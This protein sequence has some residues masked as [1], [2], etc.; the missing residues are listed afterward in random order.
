LENLIKQFEFN[1]GIKNWKKF[2]NSGGAN[3]FFF[4]LR[5]AYF[6]DYY[7]MIHFFI[8]DFFITLKR[9]RKKNLKIKEKNC[10]ENFLITF[11]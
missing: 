8:F 9:N 2:K 6:Y 4:E 11:F 3:F 1:V 5:K 10:I 7:F